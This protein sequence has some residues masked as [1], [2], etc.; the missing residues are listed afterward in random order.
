[1]KRLIAFGVSVLIMS[2]IFMRIDTRE[3]AEH[4]SKIDRPL[5]FLAFFLFIPQILIA[6]I[7]WRFL[8]KNKV[9]INLWESIK[10]ILSA[11]ALN[12]FLPSKIGDLCKAYFMKKQGQLDLKRGTNMVLFER[13]MDLACLSLMAVIGVLLASEW[14]FSGFVVFGIGS[15]VV[16]LFPILYFINFK[17]NVSIPLI[18][19]TGWGKK[20]HN[21]LADSQEY[22]LEIKNDHK[23]LLGFIGLS[24][25][26]WFL[27]IFQ[28]FIIFNAI[29]AQ[30]PFWV[31]FSL[32]PLAIFIGLLPITIAGIGSRDAAL[33]VLFS[34]Y[35]L[36][37]KIV[38][39]GLFASVR[40]F[41][42]GLLGIPFL[43]NYI[44]KEEKNV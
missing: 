41:V 23:M 18:G 40:Y 43:N 9:T 39:V 29:H 17:K 7:R 30:V 33:I 11:S 8:V 24:I 16:S 4:I 42:P 44:V 20:I 10:L 12:V 14:N 3:F 38:F 21:F 26:L 15:F 25:V 28:F 1:M 19:E 35:T 34:P 13:Y 32:V 36:A 5:L 27:H 31:I 37:S 2:L 22:L 6:A